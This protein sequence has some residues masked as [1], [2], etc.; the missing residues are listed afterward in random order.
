MPP[1][2]E[3]A[4]LRA[5]SGVFRSLVLSFSL[6][7]AF[8]SAQCRAPDSPPLLAS[9]PD[10]AYYDVPSVTTMPTFAALTPAFTQ[11][12]ESINKPMWRWS[13]YDFAWVFSGYL[14]VPTTGTW[15]LYSSSRSGSR[16]LIG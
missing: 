15:T 4:R 8:A 11:H 6:T 3:L 9:G 1:A 12:V 13:S 14:I 2:P 5:M 10:L 16:F 7:A